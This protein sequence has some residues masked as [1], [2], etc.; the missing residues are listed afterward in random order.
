MSGDA[1]MIRF[2]LPAVALGLAGCGD[3]PE[4]APPAR[5]VA[6]SG[7][8]DV[9]LDRVPAEVIAAAVAAQPGFR[10]EQ[11]Q[12]EVRDGR[13][14]F[15]LEGSLPDGSELEFDL[16]QRPEGWTV[17]E[18]Q[19]DVDF[20]AAPEPVRAASQKADADFKPVRVIESR[21]NGGLVIYELFGP[22]PEG[23]QGRKVEIKYDGRSAELL[24]K[25][26]A[27]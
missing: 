12:S 20:A 3:R 26:W 6:T 4:E 25:E 14:Y 2:L 21:Q 7:K 27:H 1:T 19:R 8:V 18:T 13:N 22:A 16:L 9:P 24:T 5:Q 17:V 10:P 15:D 11:A 23:Q